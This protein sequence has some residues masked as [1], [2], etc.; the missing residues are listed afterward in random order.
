[1]EHEFFSNKTNKKNI[2][3]RSNSPLGHTREW[4]KK[5]KV[6]FFLPETKARL[7]DFRKKGDSYDS[8]VQR[9][10]YYVELN[11]TDYNNVIAKKNK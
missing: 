7:D 8:I 5:R 3:K 9:L 4:Q 1:M 11:I 2:N 10:L 6:V